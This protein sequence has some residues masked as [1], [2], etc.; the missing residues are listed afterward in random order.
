MTTVIRVEPQRI[1]TIGHQNQDLLRI[2]IVL[3]IVRR[4]TER[5]GSGKD[6]LAPNHPCRDISVGLVF[7]SYIDDEV[8]DRSEQ[9]G[10]VV[11]QG[12]DRAQA[13]LARFEIAGIGNGAGE[14][15]QAIGSRPSRTD[16]PEPFIGFTFSASRAVFVRR[17]R[18][19]F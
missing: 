3:V 16:A 14:V 7:I 11:A 9:G 19:D 4:F 2:D 6:V 10:F 15:V 5:L 18:P 17:D 8:V 13:M 12:D 1:V